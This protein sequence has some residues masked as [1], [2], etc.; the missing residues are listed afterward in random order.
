M[1]LHFVTLADSTGPGLLLPSLRGP[2]VASVMLHAARNAA[3]IHAAL[4]QIPLRA[5]TIP[6]Q[7]LA[8]EDH[9]LP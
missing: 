1:P 6:R 8:T 9:S 5:G 7:R 3:E 2:D 4:E